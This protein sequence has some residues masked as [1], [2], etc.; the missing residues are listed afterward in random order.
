MTGLSI[1]ASGAVLKVV[2][3]DDRGALRMD[4]FEKLLSPRTKFVS[5]VHLSNSLGTINDVK[6]I[7]DL[8]SD[9]ADASDA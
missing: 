7:I 9:D 1:R 8:T 5:V 4:E 6:T 2:P 3:F